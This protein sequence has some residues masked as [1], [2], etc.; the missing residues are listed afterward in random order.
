M[1]EKNFLTKTLNETVLSRRSFLKWSAALGGAAAVAGGLNTGLSLAKKA[2]GTAE[3]SQILMTSCIHN[4]GGRCILRAEVKDGTVIRLLPDQSEDLVNRPRV[5]AC[6]RGR[7]QRRRTYSPERLKYPM[8]RVGKRGEGKFEKITWEEA[9]DTIASEM[10]RIKATYGNE[11][12]LNHYSSGTAGQINFYGSYGG[13]VNRLLYM[14]G[15]TVNEYGSYSTACLSAVTPYITATSSGNSAS[16]LKNSKLIVLFSMNPMVTQS[17]GNGRGYDYLKAKQ[18][19]ARFI[20]VD[21]RQTDSVIGLEADWVPI[22]PGTDVALI[23]AMA[24]V[25]VKED[26][27]DKEFVAKYTV[28]FDETNLPEDAPKHSSWMSY[29]MGY[30]DGIAKTPEWASPITGIPVQRIID[31]ARDIAQTKP[32]ALLQGYGWQRRAY[33]EQPPR[34]LPILAAM[35]GN[36]GKKGG[37]IGMSAGGSAGGVRMGGFPTGTNPITTTISCFMWPDFIMRGHEMTVETDRIKGAER[38]TQDLKFLWNQAGNTVI[39]Q[40]S[41]C[42]GTVKMLQDESKCEFILTVDNMLTSSCKVSDIVLPDTT[43]LEREDIVVGSGYT[44]FSRQTI[45]PMFECGDTLWICE[46]L[47]DR[48]GIGV[49]FREGHNSREDW[50]R[51]MVDVAREAQPDFPTYEEFR[52]VGVYRVNDPEP[53]ILLASFV[54]DPVA[55]PLK[56]ETG[57]IEIFSPFLYKQNEPDEIPAI[58][59]Y[60]P[61]WEG[62]SDPLRKKFP[63][64]MVGGHSMQRSHSTFD[65]VDYLQHAH[66]QCIEINLTDA[67]SRGIKNGDKVRVF[68]DR[69]TVIV[70]AKVTPRI[71]PG[72][73]CIPQG[74]WFTPDENGDDIRG[75]TNTLTKYHPTPFAKGNPQHT[76]LV[77]VEKA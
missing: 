43:H 53:S 19:G 5:I 26:L 54:E 4:C 62:V 56:T 21:P 6:V 16:D 13:P 49:E 20:V 71:R 44:A 68:N 27:Y 74:A 29:I 33:G 75:C 34:A 76:N 77:Q 14:F 57:K 64:L 10:K 8:K 11:A 35:T 42:N 32:C 51:D 36:F 60:I 48:L 70:P 46:Q 65:N 66:V 28:G 22:Y 39:N 15:G 40:H 30:A 69:G 12:F 67:E 73:T 2:A 55:N 58:P 38:M 61:E 7:A 50:L 23:A 41:D 31:L 17:G 72:V 25:M 45:E 18:A 52:D 1:T 59:K 37:S 47:A 63:L 9:L 3:G 24:Y